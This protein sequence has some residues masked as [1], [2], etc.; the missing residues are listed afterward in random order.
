MKNNILGNYCVE[1]EL[2]TIGPGSSIG[3]FTTLMNDTYLI[4][5]KA[6]ADSK[7]FCIHKSDIQNYR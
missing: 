7:I 6:A 5:V 2:D 4:Q 1:F 3:A